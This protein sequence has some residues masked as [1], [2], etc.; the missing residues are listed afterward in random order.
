M[1]RSPRGYK[2]PEL[3]P[4]PEDSEMGK[5]VHD[6]GF[7]GFGRSEDQPPREG[8]A[9]LSRAT[10]PP[11]SSVADRD[12]GWLDHQRRSVPLDL[13]LDRGA[14]PHPQPGLEDRGQIASLSR[15]GPHDQLIAIVA[16]FASDRGA[17]STGRR[18][19]DTQ[20]VRLPA[21]QERATVAERTQRVEFRSLALLAFEVPPQPDLALG[22][23]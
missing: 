8:E 19:Q 7:E 4:V 14:R 21:K 6:H 13:A 3:R 18:S 2:L 15:A 1:I 16:T 9:A 22:H 11:R 12:F 5:L 20:P 23:E 10:P 17:T